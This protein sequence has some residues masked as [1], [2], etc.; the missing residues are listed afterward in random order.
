MFRKGGGEDVARME[1]SEIRGSGGERIGLSRIPLR[2]MRATISLLFLG[3]QTRVAAGRRGVDRDHLLQ[4]KTAQIIR[5][6]R[7]RSGAGEAASTEGL[8]P[9]HGAD[10]VAV[11]VDIA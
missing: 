9:D 5:A 3:Q 4:G 8:G 7:L 1:R 2:S 10:H 11:D 6:A